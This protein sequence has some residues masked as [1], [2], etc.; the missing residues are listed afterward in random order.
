MIEKNNK[1]TLYNLSFIVLVLTAIASACGLF[2][3]GF[4][5][6]NQW[7][8]TQ[9]RGADA[10]RLFLFVPLF[11][12]AIV[13][14]K[15]G[16]LRAHLLWLGLLWTLLYDYA[17]YLFAAVFNE[18]FLIYVV[19]LTLPILLLIVAVAKVDLQL[20]KHSFSNKTPRRAIAVYLA[21]VALL[22]GGMW[23]AQ[24]IGFLVT[25]EVPVSIVDSEH[26]TAI[27]FALDLSLLVP[28]LIWAA[29]A[30]WTKHSWGYILGSL[31]LVKGAIYPVALL[32]MTFFSSRANVEGA[33]DL[34]G[35]W[36]LF[37]L[38]GLIAALA[39]FGNIKE[40]NNLEKS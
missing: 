27:I 9:F 3:E 10:V 30:L 29:I 25:G 4:Y 19:L 23:L 12:A 35:F 38:G 2:W 22:L 1:T 34:L 7:V 33:T 36:L 37:S 31:M 28:G 20:I 8:T 24:S 16:S 18:L 13:Y 14:G 40:S 11:F 32:G 21:A 5:R 6:D 39:F 17:F 26:P 15:K